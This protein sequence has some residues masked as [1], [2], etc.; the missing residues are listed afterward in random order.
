MSVALLRRSRKGGKA[1]WLRGPGLSEK[2][3]KRIAGRCLEASPRRHQKKEEKARAFEDLKTYE[4]RP[5]RKIGIGI[6]ERKPKRIGSYI[7]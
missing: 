4:W 5:E 6:R 3:K 1:N 7:R 2:K